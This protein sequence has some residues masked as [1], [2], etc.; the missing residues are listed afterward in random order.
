[1]RYSRFITVS[2]LLIAVLLLT[3]LGCDKRVFE[4]DSFEI[5]SLTSPETLYS[6]F[7]GEI[8]ALVVTKEGVPA[9]DQTVTFKTDIGII[10]SKAVSDNF[11]LAKTSFYYT[12]D[13]TLETTATIEASIQQ[14]K[15]ETH[16]TVLPFVG[17]YQITMSAV[18]D[19]IY[20]DNNITFSEI[21]ARVVDSE[22]FPAIDTPVRFKTDIGNVISQVM[23]DE[24]GVAATTFSD[25]GD[26]GTATVKAVVGEVEGSISVEIVESPEIQEII[27]TSNLDDLSLETEMSLSASVIDELGDPVA[28]GTLVTFSVSKGQLYEGNI[29]QTVDGQ[30]SVPFNTG[31]SAGLLTV[32]A[33]IGSVSAS[34]QGNIFPDL[35]A[36]ISVGLQKYD[37]NIAEWVEIPPDEGIPVNYPG[38]VRVRARVRDMH[39]NSIPQTP[40][41]FTTSLGSIQGSSLTNPDG[42]AYA[43]FFPGNS[44]GT[45]QIAASTLQMGE[46]DEA[47]T[48]VTLI[49][50]FSDEVHSISFTADGEI[51]LAVINT[52][53]V[54]ARTL[55]IE[56]YDFNGNLVSGDNEVQYEIT[57]QP[58][59]PTDGTPYIPVKINNQEG[60]VIVMAR[61]GTATASINSGTVSGT[62]TV[63]VTLVE[64]IDN[65]DMDEI[66]AIKSNIIV[67]AG[68]P[69]SIQPN[70][71]YFDSGEAI[72]GGNW[73]VQA[74]AYVKDR[75]NNNVI[76][77]TAVWFSIGDT[78]QPPQNCYIGGAGYTGIPAPDEDEGTSG[79]AVTYLYYHGENTFDEIT[80]VA[81]SGNVS[82]SKLLTLPIQQP[83]ME[84]QATLGHI[85]YFMAQDSPYDSTLNE[86]HVSLIDGQGNDITGGRVLLTASHGEFEE[87][88]WFDD[89][90]NLIN[91][92]PYSHPDAY[93]IT[94]YNGL[95]KG[96]I[97][98]W[99]YECPPPG[100]DDHFSQIEV[101][102]NAYLQGTNTVSQAT[103]IIRIYADF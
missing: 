42:I 11:G 98:T 51:N 34:K 78:P 10:G 4:P 24:T 28:D 86:L 60:P 72:G 12:M 62:V 85:D 90:G 57:H 83:P 25:G 26:I 52:G 75:Y 55:R 82:G 6:G 81:E 38:D 40:L 20:S 47:I 58:P 44:A 64:S 49:T 43:N 18:P 16:V 95:A 5:A 33:R 67:N 103:F 92:S 2:T 66:S 76:D 8:E 70:I 1:M 69:H 41:Q 100:D 56:L 71:S 3:L 79:Y 23:T 48:G 21:K 30:A 35:P 87:Y 63:K 19:T 7:E 91:D 88:Q 94:T 102:I 32:T 37:D 77:G 13:D 39:N 31:V 61:E 29:G 74:G 54:E 73:R 46:D 84:M 59:P 45:A 53:G 101:V 93:Y 36:A 15:K 17:E 97:R 89:Q 99:M 27:I 80:I 96:S 14:S 68:P 65:P 9:A 50:I 22:G